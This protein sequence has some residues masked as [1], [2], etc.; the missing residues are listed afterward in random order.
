[1]RLIKKIISIIKK[2]LSKDKFDAVD[3]DGNEYKLTKTK[4]LKKINKENK[5]NNKKQLS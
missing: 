2:H 3:Y 1:L 4:E 5:T